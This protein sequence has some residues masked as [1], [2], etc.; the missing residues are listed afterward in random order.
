MHT[1]QTPE[2]GTTVVGV[3]WPS[4]TTNQNLDGAVGAA[5]STS[6][7]N[8]LE[9]AVTTHSNDTAVIAEVTPQ[10]FN[11][12]V[13][14]A[15]SELTQELREWLS[16]N[17]ETY[18]KV[19]LHGMVHD[20]KLRDAVLSLP[21]EEKDLNGMENA[22]VFQAFQ[23]AAML[24]RAIGVEIPVPTSPTFL[25]PH[26][27]AATFDLEVGEPERQEAMKMIVDLQGHE[28]TSLHGIILP[29]LASWFGAKR[30]KRVARNF[31]MYPVP[32]VRALTE[33]L[34]SDLDAACGLSNDIENRKFDYSKQP[35]PPEQI[36]SLAGFPIGT[37]GNLVTIQGPVKSAKTSVVEAI[38]AAALKYPYI[39][40]DTLGFASTQPDGRA[41]IKLDSEQSAHDHDRHVRRVYR[42]AK[43]AEEA[44]W[45][46]SYHLT[47]M[48]PTACWSMLLLAI[49]T[50]S[51]DHGGITMILI[52]GIAD[53]CNDPNDGKECFELVR[54]LHK[55]AVDHE[56]VIV[57]VIHENPGN[58]G[59][60]TR[61]HLGSHLDRK[62]ETSLRLQ[63]D[64][65]TGV[66]EMWVER[67]RSCF[68]PRSAGI[69]FKWS[70]E[71]QMFVTLHASDTHVADS[72]VD[73]ATRLTREVDLVFSGEE[74]LIYGMLVDKI[75]SSQKLAESTA[76]QRV[77]D[78]VTLN[79][80]R[81]NDDGFY[82]VLRSESVE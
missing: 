59:G 8:T 52:D 49:K 64:T 74:G 70:D 1:N 56:C 14:T 78:Y 73:K 6:S 35:D 40:C 47:G 55:L 44:S 80:I 9:G 53:F 82:Q 50:A 20:R 65:K 34:M 60:K 38:M 62:A 48:D 10:T 21:F 46:H 76:K 28:L 2:L 67:G 29:C 19:L 12:P 42:R 41:I 30:A 11:A 22:L 43:R 68:I 4:E 77:A 3:S 25:E 57:C 5:P 31:L 17:V 15:P 24:E 71:A 54:K 39:T 7:N 13:T 61:G 66:V 58:G 81:K 27:E 51:K 16:A 32:D 75:M 37:P 33:K 18:E 72:K 26:V 23:K 63:K 69:R 79:L 36:I 45:L